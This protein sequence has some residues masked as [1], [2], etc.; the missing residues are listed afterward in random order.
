MDRETYPLEGTPSRV[1]QTSGICVQAGLE[2]S[3]NIDYL[4]RYEKKS[5]L[6]YVAASSLGTLYNIFPTEWA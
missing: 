6:T 1:H 5:E 3:T 2:E 4:F